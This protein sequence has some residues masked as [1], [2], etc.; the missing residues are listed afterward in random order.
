MIR[1]LALAAL[2]LLAVPA[3]AAA[4]DDAFLPTPYTADQIREAF[5]AG[6]VYLLEVTS[7]NGVLVTRTRVVENGPETAVLEAQLLDDDGE[8]DGEPG[9]QTAK[10]T[11]LRDHAR[12]P[13]EV[14]SRERATRETALGELEGW[15][16]RAEAPDGSIS[17]FFFADAYPGP[18]VEYTRSK[19]GEVML[20]AKMTERV[21]PE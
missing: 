10:W 7:P 1:R 18:P 21:A 9:R 5:P 15:V 2:I 16:Y 12:F 17:E 13:A 19:D 8:P 6:L 14:A 11:A 20:E 3:F 4:A